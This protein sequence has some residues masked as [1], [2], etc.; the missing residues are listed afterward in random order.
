MGKCEKHIKE[1]YGC[2]IV[3]YGSIGN[4]EISSTD[5]VDFNSMYKYS[6]ASKFLIHTLFVIHFHFTKEQINLLN[7]LY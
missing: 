7:Y 1:K 4:G 2:G 5:R 3:K 6:N